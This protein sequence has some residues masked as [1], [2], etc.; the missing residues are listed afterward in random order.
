MGAG[1]TKAI[2]AVENTAGTYFAGISNWF[3][4]AGLIVLA[5]VLI[6]IG[7]IVLM[8]D[9]GGKETA[10]TMMEVAAA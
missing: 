10:Q 1:L 8:W 6:A 4:R 2:A 9:H 7:L 3:V 5:I